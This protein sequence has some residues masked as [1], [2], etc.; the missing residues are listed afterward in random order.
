MANSTLVLI[1]LY[2][3]HDVCGRRIQAGQSLA[4]AESTPPKVSKTP[5][6]SPESPGEPA[7][8]HRT[9]TPTFSPLNA[10]NDLWRLTRESQHF[11]AIQ[12]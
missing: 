8:H 1:T 4:S 5:A 12:S 2:E 11:P 7:L 3:T 6:L 9:S 10:P